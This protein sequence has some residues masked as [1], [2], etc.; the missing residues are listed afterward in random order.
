MAVQAVVDDGRPLRYVGAVNRHAFGSGDVPA[1]GDEGDPPARGI[2]RR[3]DRDLVPAHA[4]EHP[5]VLAILPFR[6]DARA[7]FRGLSFLHS[8]AK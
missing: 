8:L 4:P 7:R 6:V 3:R 1:P 5:P 2:D